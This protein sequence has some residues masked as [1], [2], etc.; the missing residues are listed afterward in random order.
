MWTPNEDR[1]I[2]ER[3]IP[4]LRSQGFTDLRHE[5][6]GVD[7]KPYGADHRAYVI[8]VKLDAC[9]SC[10]KSVIGHLYYER[11]FGDR[12]PRARHCMAIPAEVLLDD[13]MLVQIE[14][15]ERDLDIGTLLIP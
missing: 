15:L 6:R 12:S 4:Y 10:I 11:L 7:L 13:L 2:A 1:F 14:A 5:R 3:V 9:P 8:E